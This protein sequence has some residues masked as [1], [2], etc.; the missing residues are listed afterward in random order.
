MKSK[1]SSMIGNMTVRSGS[2]YIV[3]GSVRGLVSEHRTQSGAQESLAG[4]QR[5]CK[6]QGGYSDA[7]VYQWDGESWEI[8]TSEE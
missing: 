3:Y 8:V 2:S 4:D 7:R 6:S 1:H 5:G